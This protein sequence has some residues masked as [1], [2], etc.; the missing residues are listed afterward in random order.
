MTRAQ[1]TYERIVALEAEGVPKADAFKQLAEEY[2]QPVNSIRGAY[3]TGRRHAA[4]EGSASRP[5]RSKKRETTEQD[6]IQAAIDT[7]E[8]SIEDIVSEVEAADERARE[9]VAEHR[10]LADA[11]GSRIEAIQAKITL[12]GDDAAQTRGGRA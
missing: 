10:A 3:Y 6:A 9:A 8:A 11:S 4:G 12:L 1:E 2:R 5:R 7:L